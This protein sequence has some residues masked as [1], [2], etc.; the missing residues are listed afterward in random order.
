MGTNYNHAKIGLSTDQSKPLCIF[1]DM[2]QQGA[3]RANYAH[4]GQNMASSQNGRGGTFYVL[5]NQQLFDS[6]TQLLKGDTEPTSPPAQEAPS[7]GPKPPLKQKKSPSVKAKPKSV[8]T[9]KKA[10][11]KAAKKKP[12]KASSSSSR[13]GKKTALQAT[14]K[15]PRKSTGKKAAKSA[16]PKFGAAAKKAGKKR[17]T[18]ARR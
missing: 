8:A 5:K 14:A 10:P 17:P 18:K 16:K 15:A 11:K 3:L 9:A 4:A 13:A 6:L 1:G 12:S 7:P 2:N